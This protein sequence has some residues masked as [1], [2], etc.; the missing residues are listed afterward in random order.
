[1][2]HRS[3]KL[4]I[5]TKVRIERFCN[6]EFQSSKKLYSSIC[7]AFSGAN[8]E[9]VDSVSCAL[10]N[11]LR[12]HKCF[13]SYW[14]NCIGHCIYRWWD[15]PWD[16]SSN[17]FNNDHRMTRW[18]KS[19]LCSLAA[20]LVFILAQLVTN[21]VLDSSYFGY[22]LGIWIGVEFS[23][24]LLWNWTIRRGLRGKDKLLR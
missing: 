16:R 2:S 4:I 3:K 23:L 9:R 20:L 5:K 13:I 19:G 21:F 7:T 15:W 18:C 14:K 22:Y 11:W 12:S 1:M 17:S 10:R 24:Y 6:A 8:S